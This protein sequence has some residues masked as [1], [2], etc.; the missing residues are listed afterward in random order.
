[1]KRIDDTTIQFDNILFDTNENHKRMG[2]E[3]RMCNRSL[4]VGRVIGYNEIE[5]VWLL[6]YII[7]YG[8]NS[9]VYTILKEELFQVV[10]KLSLKH[11]KQDG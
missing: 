5:D 11:D 10:E 3:F 7:P 4:L 1:M 2:N 6:R 8:E 9:D